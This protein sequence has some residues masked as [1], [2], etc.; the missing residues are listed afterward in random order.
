MPEMLSKHRVNPEWEALEGKPHL[1]PLSCVPDQ[2]KVIKVGPE[3][4]ADIVKPIRGNRRWRC[5]GCGNFPDKCK[6]N[7]IDV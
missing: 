6:C 3:P 1:V 7:I 2:Y 4:L 5:N